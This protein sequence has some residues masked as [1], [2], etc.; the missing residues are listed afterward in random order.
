M[1]KNETKRLSPSNI[2]ADQT[3]FSV[4]QGISTYQPSNAAYSIQEGENKLA[5]LSQLQN[6]EAQ[7]TAALKSARDNTVTAEW[8]FHN[9]I[10]GVK[11]QVMAQYGDSSNEIQSLGLKK[12]TEYNKRGKA[13]AAKA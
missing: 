7:A 1:A 2:A 4:L 13:A 6:T 8:D 10:L 11:N 3:I 5:A 9:Y 12:K